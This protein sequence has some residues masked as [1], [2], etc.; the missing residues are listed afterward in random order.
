MIQSFL[1][2]ISTLNLGL[3]LKMI[4]SLKSSGKSRN[5]IYFIKSAFYFNFLSN[6]SKQTHRIT[7][8]VSQQKKLIEKMNRE[9]L[10]IKY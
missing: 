5:Y 7:K 3:G 8:S 4:L 9:M 1:K 2:I 10:Q 6:D